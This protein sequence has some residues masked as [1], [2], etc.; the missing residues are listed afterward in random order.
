M[1]ERCLNILAEIKECYPNLS[2]INGDALKFA[3]DENYTKNGK[4]HIVSNL[5]YNISV[6]LLC[7]WL[8]E[9]SK[10]KSLTL[11]FQKEVADRIMAKVGSKDYGRI[12]IFAQIKF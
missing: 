3:W 10:Y 11:M 4:C 9:I 12:Y 2:I 1:D 7:N 8:L 5:P 6:V